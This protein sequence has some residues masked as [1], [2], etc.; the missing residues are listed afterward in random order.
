MTV[1]IPGAPLTLLPSNLSY[2][3]CFSADLRQDAKYTSLHTLWAMLGCKMCPHA[4][5]LDLP[6][7]TWCR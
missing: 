5:E 4:Q 6:Y 3:I 2:L 7:G 1:A